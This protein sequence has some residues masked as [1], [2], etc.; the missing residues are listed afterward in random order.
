LEVVVFCG[1]VVVLDDVELDVPKV[2]NGVN[3]KIHTFPMIIHTK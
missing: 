1:G 2:V 3:Q